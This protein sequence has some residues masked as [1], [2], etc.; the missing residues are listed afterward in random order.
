MARGKIIT[1]IVL[2]VIFAAAAFCL[3]PWSVGGYRD[4]RIMAYLKYW[5]LVVPQTKNPSILLK[6]LETEDSRVQSDAAFTIAMLDPNPATIDGLRQLIDRREA[7]A[8]AKDAAIW[9][10]GELR[11]TAAI[12]QLKDRIGREGVDQ[13]VLLGAIE[14]IEGRREKGFFPE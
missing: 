7:E 1:L 6:N 10:L 9:A 2:L 4:Y 13:T 12:E 14:K 8:G 5:K 11:A 3:S